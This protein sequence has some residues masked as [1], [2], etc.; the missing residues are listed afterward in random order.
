MWPFLLGAAPFTALGSSIK[1]K[2]SVYFALVGVALVIAGVRLLW[3]TKPVGPEDATE[4]KPPVGLTVGA[5][6]G[7]LSGL[8]G[9]GGGIFLSPVLMLCRWA[10]AKKAA[11]TSAAFIVSNSLIGLVVRQPNLSKLPSVTPWL[12]VAGVTGS[13]LGSYLGTQKV[14]L[15]WLQRALGALLLLASIKLFMGH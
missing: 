13:I 15:V 9:V 5:G 11:A 3:P 1:I 2:P 14:S 4:P 8:V 6:I 7:V 10:D 12:I